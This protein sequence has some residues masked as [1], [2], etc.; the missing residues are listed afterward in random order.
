MH[1]VLVTARHPSWLGG[2]ARTR[3]PSSPATCWR[4]GI[5][6]DKT[7]GR[8]LDGAV[9]PATAGFATLQALL[10]RLLAPPAFTEGTY[11]CTKASPAGG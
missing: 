1:A 6:V 2:S 5:E 9:R 4:E 11:D 7:S 8:V 10:V 3:E